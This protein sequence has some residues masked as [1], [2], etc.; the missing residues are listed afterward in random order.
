MLKLEIAQTVKLFYKNYYNLNIINAAKTAVF[1]I[2]INM[3]VLFI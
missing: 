3:L 1:I 2:N